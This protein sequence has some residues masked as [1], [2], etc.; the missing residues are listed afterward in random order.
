MQVRE[1]PGVNQDPSDA[2]IRNRAVIPDESA[3]AALTKKT[4]F[5]ISY[6]SVKSIGLYIDT[7]LHVFK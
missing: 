6:N 2:G 5:I 3:A 1:A 7:I 4:E